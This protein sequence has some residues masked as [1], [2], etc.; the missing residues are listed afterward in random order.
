MPVLE[1]RHEDGVVALSQPVVFDQKYWSELRIA[2]DNND[3]QALA[4][5]LVEV[6]SA[7]FPEHDRQESFADYLRQAFSPRG[8]Y[9][10]ELVNVLQAW[11]AGDTVRVHFASGTNGERLY[12]DGDERA[13]F[14]QGDPLRPY[15]QERFIK[16]FG[17]TT[18]R[19]NL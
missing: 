16:C 14:Y 6:I 8:N 11:Q 12:F 3:E 9:S 2:L 13:M 18:C 5:K 10:H 7:F 17:A 4:A 19:M 15:L 1:D